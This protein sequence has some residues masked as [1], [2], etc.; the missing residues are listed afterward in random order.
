MSLVKKRLNLDAK[1][2]RELVI[3]VMST[4]VLNQSGTAFLDLVGC[5]ITT[6]LLDGYYKRR[7]RV[8]CGPADVRTVN[9]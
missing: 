8:K 1:C 9:G 7:P 4:V 2:N 5:H 6:M 3:T